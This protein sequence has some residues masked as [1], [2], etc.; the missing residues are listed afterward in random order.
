MSFQKSFEPF[1][2]IMDSDH[3]Y[4]VSRATKNDYHDEKIVD[5]TLL[6]ANQPMAIKSAMQGTKITHLSEALHNLNLGA[7]INTLRFADRRPDPLPKSFEII[8]V[9]LK[10]DGT[11]VGTEEVIAA[12][13]AERIAAQAARQ[14]KI[15]ALLHKLDACKLTD[16]HVYNLE[17]ML[18]HIA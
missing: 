13:D 1:Y 17:E 7:Q 10:I 14:E 5:V 9:D 6:P 4:Y 8:K 3:T 2:C 18:S 12:V 16:Y 11:I 15:N